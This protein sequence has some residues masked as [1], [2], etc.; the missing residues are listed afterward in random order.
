MS[1][2][3]QILIPPFSTLLIL[4]VTFLLFLI[5]MLVNRA[6]MNPKQLA[7]WQDEINR[8]NAEKERAKKTGDKKL[9]SKVKKQ[10]KIINQIESR[11]LKRQI[12]GSMTLASLYLSA[13]FLLFSIYGTV[14]VAYVPFWVPFISPFPP[15]PLQL[16]LWYIICSYFSSSILSRIFGL[17]TGLSMQPR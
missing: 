3:E 14:G 6:L 7:A 10:E 5:T 11:R 1:I 15:Y 13:W 16:F 12:I 8:F 17:R 4:G 9:M 2:A